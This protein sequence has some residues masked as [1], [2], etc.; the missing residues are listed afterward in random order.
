MK[1]S[2]KPVTHRGQS[3]AGTDLQRFIDLANADP[4]LPSVDEPFH[5]ALADPR[6]Q[7]TDPRDLW[8]EVCTTVSARLSPETRTF[9]G[10]AVDLGLFLERYALLTSARQVLRGLAERYRSKKQHAQVLIDD[11]SFAGGFPVSITVNLV[12]DEKGLLTPSDDQLLSVFTGV[13]AN[14]IRS[15]DV[16]NRLFWA[17]RDNSECCSERCRKTSNQRNSRK[18]RREE[19]TRKKA[20]K[21]GR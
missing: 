2:A 20:L 5:A 8:I 15:C 11:N 14:R 19:I 21:R 12:V 4:V 1:N 7:S 10:P 9:L 6:N 17:P 3:R 18:A 16:C 13:P